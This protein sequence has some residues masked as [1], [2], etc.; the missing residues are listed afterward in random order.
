MNASQ[1]QA[2]TFKPGG[3]DF[4]KMRFNAMKGG[5]SLK[6]KSDPVK[7]KL[8]KIFGPQQDADVNKVKDLLEEIKKSK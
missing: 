4:S 3:M 6:K 1:L 2:P 7:E 5:L 8:E